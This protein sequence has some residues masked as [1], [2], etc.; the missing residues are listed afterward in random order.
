MHLSVLIVIIIDFQFKCPFSF[1]M[2]LLDPLPPLTL[3]S[4]L[5]LIRRCSHSKNNLD[6]TGGN[7]FS[8]SNFFLILSDVHVIFKYSL[9]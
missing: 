6:Y 5:L 9:L 1:P 3:Q 7:I 8:S 4:H 2:C